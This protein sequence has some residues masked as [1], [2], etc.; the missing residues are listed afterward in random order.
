VRI[1]LAKTKDTFPRPRLATVQRETLME[2]DIVKTYNT[3]FYS[4]RLFSVCLITDR[5][6][7]ARSIQF[8]C[9]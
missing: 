4:Y 1:C 6:Y 9:L 8:S 3:T 2:N 5:R 7:H